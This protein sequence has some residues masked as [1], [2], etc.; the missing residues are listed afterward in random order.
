MPHAPYNAEVLFNICVAHSKHSMHTTYNS[1]AGQREKKHV[2][3]LTRRRSENSLESNMVEKMSGVP[4]WS[5]Q[6]N[7]AGSQM[8]LKQ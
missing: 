4:H 1:S 3:Y 5:A 7:T 2:N 6:L 8:K